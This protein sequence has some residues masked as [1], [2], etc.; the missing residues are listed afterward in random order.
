MSDS[1]D[2]DPFAVAGLAGDDAFDSEL[3][4]SS[5]KRAATLVPPA[6]ASAA[7]KKPAAA[8]AAP[9]LRDR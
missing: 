4:S 7:E 1:E 2:S 3:D 8:A 5:A 6:R 9:A